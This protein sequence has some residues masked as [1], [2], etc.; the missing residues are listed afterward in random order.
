MASMLFGIGQISSLPYLI[1]YCRLNY[2]GV[3]RPP[4]FSKF[5]GDTN[6]SIVEHVARYYSEA[7]DLANI[8][9]LKMKFF[10]NYLTKNAFTWFTA[11]PPHSMCSWTQLER[12]S[13]EQ[14]YIERSKINLKELASV[15][16]KLTRSID[17]YL[18][19]FRILK[20]RCFSQVPE[21][22]LV[23]LDAGDL[24][25]SIRKKLDI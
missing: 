17:D 6:E 19:M 9:N 14:F 22:E 13:H 18:N 15:R 16:H 3:G 10:P 1:M 2:Q 20:A 4:K 23:E 25:Y 12:V 7:E 5:T 24:Y 8:E 11:L 21:H